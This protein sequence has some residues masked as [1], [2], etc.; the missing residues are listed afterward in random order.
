MFRF[1]REA[2][3]DL[4][5]PPSV[6]CPLC[7][8]PKASPQGGPVCRR[9]QE[10]LAALKVDLINCFCCGRYFQKEN[11]DSIIYCKGCQ[12][13]RPGFELARA[14]GPYAGILR[15]AVH[16]LKYL[17]QLSL[18]EPLGKLMAAAIREELKRVVLEQHLVEAPRVVPIPLHPNRLGERGFNQAEL[19]AEV[20]AREL[21]LELDSGLLVR[22]TDTP[23]QTRLTREERRLNL[24]G[25]FALGKAKTVAM[26]GRPILIVDDV[27]TTGATAEECARVLRGVNCG[28]IIVVTTATGKFKDSVEDDGDDL[29]LSHQVIRVKNSDRGGFYER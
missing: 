20:V 16:Q 26:P 21:R 4:I 1:L 22:C 15:E 24:T 12:K 3:V 23:S 9:C 29:N 13:S 7:H 28:P 27:L 10:Q 6:Q 14:I 2:L 11:P 19:L 18:A 5:Y 25:A 8:K 17:G